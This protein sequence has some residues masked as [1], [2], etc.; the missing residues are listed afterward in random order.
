MMKNKSVYDIL[1]EIGNFTDNQI[2]S[3]S[4][5]T[6]IEDTW[7]LPVTS[8][9]KLLDD[10]FPIDYKIVN[11]HRDGA[12]FSYYFRGNPNYCY[13]GKLEEDEG[14]Y[15]RRL[16]FA[17]FIRVYCDLDVVGT[18][19]YDF[20][21]KE[22]QSKK[23]RKNPKRM[24][25]NL[26]DV[27]VEGYS[28]ERHKF[29]FKSGDLDIIESRFA[30]IKFSNSKNEEGSNKKVIFMTVYFP[31]YSIHNKPIINKQR[32]TITLDNSL[33]ELFY[34]TET[35]RGDIFIDFYNINHDLL[36]GTNS[37]SLSKFLERYKNMVVGDEIFSTEIKKEGFIQYEYLN[38]AIPEEIID[39]MRS[40]Y[41]LSKL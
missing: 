23:R 25:G 38:K 19:F 2:L 10:V 4:K 24:Y 27:Y 26:S 6:E 31:F 33:P 39:V 28:T 7:S 12:V 21:K 8:K 14:I 30:P 37:I 34:I 29:E 9:T 3:F 11:I 41:M 40:K 17:D 13:I 35:D 36:Y 15:Y 18:F 1:K 16:D 22:N 20:I 5:R 32:K